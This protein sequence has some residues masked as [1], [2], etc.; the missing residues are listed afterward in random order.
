MK[1]DK[2]IV[3]GQEYDL[4]ET[5]Y[6]PFHDCFCYFVKGKEKPFCS[7]DYKIEVIRCQNKD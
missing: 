7:L 5:V 3:D 2:V 4:I 1:M 6:D